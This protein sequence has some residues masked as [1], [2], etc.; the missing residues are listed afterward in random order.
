MSGTGLF[1]PRPSSS[2]L[3][4][5]MLDIYI[6]WCW[7]LRSLS[8][9]AAWCCSELLLIFIIISGLQHLH[10]LPLQCQV[11]QEVERRVSLQQARTS[12][13]WT[14]SE[15]RQPVPAPGQDQHLQHQPGDHAELSRSR[16]QHSW[17]VSYQCQVNMD[18]SQL[19]IVCTLVALTNESWLFSCWWP[20]IA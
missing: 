17:H 7:T 9:H 12:N 14:K 1:C 15:S 8:T 2:G 6:C 20:I 13:T 16:Q 4:K 5:S 11:I 10:L 19:S 3:C 18:Q